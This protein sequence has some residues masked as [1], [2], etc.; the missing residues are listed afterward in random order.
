MKIK[1]AF[2][3]AV[4]ALTA[5][6]AY[7]VLGECQPYGD[8]VYEGKPVENGM[9]VKALIGE[10]VLA[11]GTTAGGGYSIVIPADNPNTPEKD[12]W[13]EGDVITIKINGRVATPSFPAFLGS[14]RHNL[15]VAS[16]GVKLDTWGKIKALFK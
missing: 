7:A 1:I 4:I 6:S 3:L 9:E 2:V 10:M 5:Y 8:I 15:Q 12:G 11:T 13:V 14:Q 16:L